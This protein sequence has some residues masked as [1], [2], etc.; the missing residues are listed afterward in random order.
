MGKRELQIPPLRYAPV[1]MT[2][3]CLLYTSD[4]HPRWVRAP[5]DKL[6]ADAEELLGSDLRVGGKRVRRASAA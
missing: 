6:L 5:I 4:G 1:G 2:K 3:G